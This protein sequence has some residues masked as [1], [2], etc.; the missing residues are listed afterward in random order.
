MGTV[1][2]RQPPSR[3]RT[4][5]DSDHDS[6]TITASRATLPSG[7]A[8]SVRNYTSPATC[9]HQ[10]TVFRNQF[11]LRNWRQERHTDSILDS[12]K[13]VCFPCYHTPKRRKGKVHSRTGHEDQEGEQTYSSYLLSEWSR[14]LLVKLT[15]SELVKKFFAFYGTRSFITAFTN[16]CH[17]SLSWAS[18]IQSMPLHPTSWKEVQLY[19]FFNLGARWGWVVNAT[20]QLLYRQQKDPVPIVQEAGWAP[21]SVWTV[22]QNLASTGIRTPDRPVRSEPL[23]PYS[24]MPGHGTVR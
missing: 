2:F 14:V 20:S 11:R 3:H 7:E 16:A 17:L 8:I 5:S 12:L 13:V 22:V 1:T 6:S 10:Q 24:S 21:L 19:S 23:C 9:G 15:G 4:S 18:S